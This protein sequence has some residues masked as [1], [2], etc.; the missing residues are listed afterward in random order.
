[1]TAQIAAYTQKQKL[2]AERI[3][4]LEE[5]KSMML[6]TIGKIFEEEQLGGNQFIYHIND[7]TRYYNDE[8]NKL[9][10]MMN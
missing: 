9:I 8:I 4:K 1:E 6:R 5:E 3:A 2:L 7:T 10:A